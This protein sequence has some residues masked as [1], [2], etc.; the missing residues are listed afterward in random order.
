[1]GLG[2]RIFWRLGKEKGSF[3][4]GSWSGGGNFFPFREFLPGFKGYWANFP[5][6]KKGLTEFWNGVVRKKF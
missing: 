2:R 3:L 1:L 4:Q 5:R 6:A